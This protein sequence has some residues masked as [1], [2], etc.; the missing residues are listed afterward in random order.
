MPQLGNSGMAGL[1]N[2]AGSR[3]LEAASVAPAVW[4]DAASAYTGGVA[5]G[6]DVT[7]W[8]SKDSSGRTFVNASN[9]TDLSWDEADH[10]IV[11]WRVQRGGRVSATRRSHAG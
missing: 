11:G 2:E 7:T 9:I 4:L 10:G 5:D 1:V 3:T 6:S 8:T